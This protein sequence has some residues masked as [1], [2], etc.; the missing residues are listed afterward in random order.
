MCWTL[1]FSMPFKHCNT[2]KHLTLLMAFLVLWLKHSK[3]FQLLNVTRFSWH[4]NHAWWKSW[5]QKAATIIKFHI[6]KRKWCKGK[7]YV[8][9]TKM[10]S[11]ISGR[12]HSL[13]E[14]CSWLKLIL[15]FVLFSV[16]SLSW[17]ELL[18]WHVCSSWFSI[19]VIL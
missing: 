15:S 16:S 17:V 7:V 1:G 4:Y 13:L 14:R 18:Y 6:L 9:S 8:S 2:K 5:R 12:S 3:N 11:F 19:L 10:R